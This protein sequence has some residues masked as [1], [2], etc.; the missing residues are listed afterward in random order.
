MKKRDSII[1][2]A[3]AGVNHNGSM[4]RAREMVKAAAAAGA[5]YV[6]FQTAVPELVISSIA[7]KADYQKE[8][9]GGGQ[10]QLDMCRA[11]HLPL[12]AYAELKEE[13]RRAGIGF[14]STPFDLVSIDLLADLGQD[15]MKIPS[16]EITNLP[17]LRKIAA[18][19]I[20]VIMSTGM[21]T[22]EEIA[23]AVDVLTGISERYPS[24]SRLTRDDII[25]LH[26]N[27]EYPTPMGDV[28]L[29]A[30][31]EMERRLH[32][33]VGYSDHTRGIEVP[34]AA[35]A[36]GAPV[37]EKHFTLSRSLEGPDHKAS[38]EPD[39]LAEMVRC[40]RNIEQ[41]LGTPQK[42]VSPS[43]RKNMAIARKSIVAARDI[44]AGETFTADNITCKR[45]GNGISPMLW[46]S[47]I[48]RKA[49]RDFAADSLIEI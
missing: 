3:E 2:I 32:L 22:P 40:V 5:D 18:A 38:L 19:G 27:T 41:A 28:N 47:V 49:S 35:A 1:I 15:W 16:G 43:E 21:S 48:G 12:S 14:M 36:L 10:S 11:I 7:P 26:C 33:P 45:P 39:E 31:K 24:Q 34:I 23:T 8:T 9:T 37:I 29:R 6:K 20:P 46:D 44:N 30:M 25:L 42:Q 4:E 13:C 17:Y